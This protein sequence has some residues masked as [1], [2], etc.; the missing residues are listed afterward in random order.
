MVSVSSHRKGVDARKHIIIHNNLAVSLMYFIFNPIFQGIFSIKNAKIFKMPMYL[1][2]RVTHSIL[3]SD[4]VKIP[5]PFAVDPN[6]SK[7]LRKNSKKKKNNFYK[8][9]I[10]HTDTLT[11]KESNSNLKLNFAYHQFYLFIE[12]SFQNAYIYFLL[13]FTQYILFIPFPSSQ[14]RT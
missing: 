2:P 6:Q 1:H 5:L 4:S 7:L 14:N 11:H 9:F 13:S 12:N 8:I 3:S 10:T